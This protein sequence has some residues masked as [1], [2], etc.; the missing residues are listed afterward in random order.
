MGGLGYILGN[1][2]IDLSYD[3]SDP[4]NPPFYFTINDFT[5]DFEIILE[6]KDVNS[7]I[8]ERFEEM[9][10]YPPNCLLEKLFESIEKEMNKREA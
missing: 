1:I 2:M 10:K 3:I 9:E 4:K 5:T 8:I 7:G 6:I